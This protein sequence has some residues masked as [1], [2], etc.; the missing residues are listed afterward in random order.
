M[1]QWIVLYKKENL[2]MW[3]NYKWLWVPLVFI[4]L[5]MM[6]PVLNFYM[7]Q[8]LEANGIAK[9][10]LLAIPVPTAAETMIKT[11]SQFNTIGILVLVL[12]FMGTVASERQSGAAIMVLVKPVAHLS[13]VTSKWAGMLSLTIISFVLGYL[14]SW[15]YTGLLIG[16]VDF[17]QVWQSFLV[18]SL[19]LLFILSVTLFYSSLLN[20]TG[21]VAFLS[22]LTAAGFSLSSL[23]FTRYMKWS[24]GHLSSEAGELVKEGSS[25]TQLWMPICVTLIMIIV[26]I[27]GAVYI[28]KRKMS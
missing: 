22:L 21:G 3:R 7:P 24:P 14:V 9:E 13:Y 4:L 15:Y 10:I 20:S 18:Y 1:T 28:S 26:L 23:L 8:I 5:G 19:W 11:L 27:Y 16:N 12:S 25:Q 2:E 17:S 6:D